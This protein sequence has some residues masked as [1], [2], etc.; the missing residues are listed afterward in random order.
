M[1][2]CVI[3]LWV[4]GC[5]LVVSHLQS[6]AA[7]PGAPQP[8]PIFW[9]YAYSSLIAY[10]LPFFVLMCLRVPQGQTA[11]RY[12]RLTLFGVVL[13]TSLYIPAGRF[14]PGYHAKAL[15]GLVYIFMPLFEFGLIAVFLIAGGVTRLLSSEPADR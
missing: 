5:A 1:K 11:E 6:L 8:G 3:L 7:P 4:L 14:L 12:I 15:E 9:R 10:S 2:I 13:G